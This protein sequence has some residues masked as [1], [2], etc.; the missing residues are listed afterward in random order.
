MKNYAN[1]STKT[2]METITKDKLSELTRKGTCVEFFSAYQDLDT[3]RMVHLA[4]ANATIAFLP[5]GE[6]GKGLFREF[7]K[8][9]WTQLMDCFPDLDNTVDAMVTENDAVICK[10]MIFGT[11]KKDFLGLPANGLRF[12]SE[13]IFVFH[14]NENDQIIDL[15]I[16]WDHENF[17]AQ[18]S[19]E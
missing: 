5:L 3:D 14:F 11:Q 1:E 10:V 4:T 12:E 15:T 19:G 13:H 2:N 7:G 6:G 18:L 9:V 16:D 8:N 17:V